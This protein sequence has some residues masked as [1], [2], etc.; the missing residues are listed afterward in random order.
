MQIMPNTARIEE[1]VYE[2]VILIILPGIIA[3]QVK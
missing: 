1:R 2:K 3:A